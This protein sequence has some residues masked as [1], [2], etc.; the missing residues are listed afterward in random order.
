MLAVRTPG[1]TIHLYVQACCTASVRCAASVPAPCPRAFTTK[2]Y[3]SVLFSQAWRISGW[4]Q[5][6]VKKKGG[7]QPPY[8]YEYK[9]T[10]HVYIYVAPQVEK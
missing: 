5:V 6:G 8:E 7:S 9:W 10:L 3:S 4:G 2:R 1:A